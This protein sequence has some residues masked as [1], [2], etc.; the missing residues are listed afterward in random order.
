MGPRMT[1]RQP[2]PAAIAMGALWGLIL[3]LVAVLA[4]AQCARREPRESIAEVIDTGAIIIDTC[5]PW[6]Q[7]QDVDLPKPQN[8]ALTYPSISHII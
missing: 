6:P 8:L 5:Q 1:R 7:C 4:V 3:S 2:E